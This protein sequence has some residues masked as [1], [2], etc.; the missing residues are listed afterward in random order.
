MSGWFPIAV[1]WTLACVFGTALH[2][3]LDDPARFRAS[4]AAYRLVPESLTMGACIAVILLESLTVCALLLAT[5][6]GLLLAT[7]MLAGYA[8]AMAINVLRGRQHID[9]GCGD[10]PTP[11]SW[12]TV[13]RNLCLIALAFW[14]L[15]MHTTWP[16]LDIWGVLFCAAS[17]AIAFGLYQCAEELLANR[18]R[19]QRLWLGITT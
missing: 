17:A 14:A 16:A 5:P 1:S 13:A 3:K 15:T 6:L 7:L 18:S 11:V 2:H 10:A 19:H 8:L 12:F 9:C 4:L